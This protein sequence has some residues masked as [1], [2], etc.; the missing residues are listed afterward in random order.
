LRGNGQRGPSGGRGRGRGW[1]GYHG[2]HGNGGRWR[3]TN[4]YRIE[5]QE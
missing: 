2:N 1:R 4:N 3:G 5:A